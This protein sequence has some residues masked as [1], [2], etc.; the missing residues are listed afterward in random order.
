MSGAVRVLGAPGGRERRVLV[1]QAFRPADGGPAA[2]KGCATTTTLFRALRGGAFRDVACA[3][4]LWFVLSS[5][6]V[7]Q[8]RLAVL[9]AEDRRAPTANDLAILR[10]A[11]RS[12]DP[13]IARIG[14]RALG[15][16]E[17]PALI[18]D[19]QISLRHAEPDVR[20]EAATAIGQAA[21]GWKRDKP[22][23]A[24]LDPI[25]G[26]LAARLKVDGDAD[27]R[28]ALAE[29]I[30]RLPYSSAAQVDKAEQVL[31]EFGERSESVT[32]RLGVAKGLEAL[33]RISRRVRPL[34]P[35]AIAM[36]KRLA[37]PAT[38]VT[39]GARVRRLSLEALVTLAAADEALVTTALR[40]PDAQARRIVLR[41]APAAALATA[42]S[43]DS[44]MVRLEALRLMRT[45]NVE[46]VCAASIRAASDRD[47]HVALQALDNLAGC[48][49]AADAV[50]ILD[51]A[52]TDLA[53]AGAPRGWHRAAH[54]L[55]AL[56]AASS[57]PGAAALGQFTG[58]RVWQLRMYA[59]RAAATL[60]R[61]DALESL[62]NDEN[63]NVRDAAVEGLK[64]LAGHD[65]DTIFIAQLGR[66]GYQVVRAAAL[67]LVDSPHGEVALPALDAALDRLVAE[68]RDNSHDARDAIAKALTSLGRKVKPSATQPFRPAG[69]DSDL[70]ADDL[71][72]LAA[73]RARVTIAGLGS[74]EL[75]LF[76]AQ[77]PATV[78]R[79]ARLAERGYYNGLTFH[80]VVPNF[81]IQGGSP[82]ANE[83]IGDTRFMRDEL[84][85]WPHVR[86]AVGISTRGR[87]TGDAQIFVDLVD[88]PRLDHEYTVFAQVLNGIDVV[89]RILE[90]DVIEKVEIIAGS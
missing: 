39:S 46:A 84:G 77:A 11:A 2:L 41:A 75:A 3:L 70:N 12:G 16:L 25:L 62:A 35:D 76:T 57:E 79:F 48:G 20:A 42:A 38:E 27:V 64:A 50:A 80:R 6:A 89:D 69:A 78:L 86:G 68:A 59:A 33:A 5:S 56:A 23:G 4:L 32:D 18:A 65:A 49:E 22:A 13:Q 85:L 58:S 15:R 47:P 44:P 14:V 74:F 67:A 71:R 40:D 63:D 29:T 8:T 17:R 51:R 52:V 26:A 83:Y 66:P 53:E 9:Q 7:A 34:G 55:V 31:V 87:D 28:A 1:A 73:P 43:D 60:K 88:N 37:S 61:R 82:G 45:K 90:G 54:A 36:L 72:R 24:A 30:G 19:I 81:V 10:S 21:Q